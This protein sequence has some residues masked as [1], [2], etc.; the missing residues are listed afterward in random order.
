[1]TETVGLLEGVH[2]SELHRGTVIDLKTQ[3]R[4]YRIEYLGEDR[5]RVCGHPQW[6]PRPIVARLE[7]SLQNSGAFEPDFVGR[8]MHLVFERSDDLPPVT[9]SE[10]R[11]IS[12]VEP[13]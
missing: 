12:L 13:R 11:D 5:V 10:V 8:G 4:R 6:C 2:L 1:M 3:N 7:G 9:T